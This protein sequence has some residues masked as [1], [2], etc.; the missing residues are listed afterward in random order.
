MWIEGYHL[1]F[2]Q[3]SAIQ[4]RN[5]HDYL[6]DFESEIPCYLYAQKVVDIA[7]AAICGNSNLKDNLFRV[8]SELYRENIVKKQELNILEAWLK[9]I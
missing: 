1:C 9:D 4:E 7:N 8:Y 5:E 2:S 6:K 3:A